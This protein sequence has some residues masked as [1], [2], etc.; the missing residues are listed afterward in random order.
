MDDKLRKKVLDIIKPSDEEHSEFEK[1]ANKLANKIKRAA[2]KLQIKCEPFIGGSFGK[3]TYLKGSSDVDIFC[4]FDLDY[5]DSKLS[6]YLEA[7]LNEAKI[8][9]KKQKGSRDYFSGFFGPKDFRISFEV[10]P[11][12][13]VEDSDSAKNSTDLSPLHVSFLKSKLESN[14]NLTDEIRLAKQFFKAK[15]LY[16]AESYINGFSGHVIDI[17]IIE[18]GSL[19]NLIQEAQ[20]WN[21]K[22]FID[23][24][25]FYEN[26]SKAQISL[27]KDKESSLV[28][29][30]PIIKDRNAARALSEENYAKFL[31]ICNNVD[32]L[33]FEDFIVVHEDFND[34]IDSVKEF[35]KENNLKH[36]IYKLNFD[37]KNE[38]ED[39][40]GSKLKKLRKKI[41]TYFESFD[42]VV[43]SDEFFIDISKGV[44][45][46]IF[47]FEK[48]SLPKVKIL[49]G[50]KT[51]M[52]SAI[53]VFLKDR[54]EYFIKDDRVCV[55]EKR[56]ILKL[57]EV[58]NLDIDAMEKMLARNVRFVKRVKIYK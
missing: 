24:S 42:F 55:Y 9:Y 17:L 57:E 46:F 27:G 41:K 22:T 29:I 47:T 16:G 39:I 2:K 43:F 3:G 25:K 51:Y 8:K 23:V 54:S 49:N 31:F 6:T 5:D 37:V 38:S 36:L 21:D 35:A 53:K 33:K 18:F 58:Y 40:V 12:R 30:D 48:V 32:E 14:P 44:C 20:S 26:F 13:L 1:V 50:P 15:R 7:I 52:K 34:K 56:R 4:R 45:L 19:E 10:V 11:N 28:L